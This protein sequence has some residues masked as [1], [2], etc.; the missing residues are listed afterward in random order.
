MKYVGKI[1]VVS[2]LTENLKVDLQ[3]LILVA[4]H[5][6]WVYS[7][8]PACLYDLGQPICGNFIYKCVYCQG[9]RFLEQKPLTDDYTYKQNLYRW[10]NHYKYQS[11]F[12]KIPTVYIMTLKQSK[13]S[14]SMDVA[15]IY[16]FTPT[17]RRHTTYLRLHSVTNI[18]SVTRIQYKAYLY[19]FESTLDRF[20]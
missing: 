3:L 11:V 9:H 12:P 10:K 5:R 2:N 13:F 18:F 6:G 7:L 17:A 8:T 1:A 15:T 19:S 14:S 4:R 16:N 20:R